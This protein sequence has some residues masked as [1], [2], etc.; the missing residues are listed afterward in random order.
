MA[1]ASGPSK[2]SAGAGRSSRPTA[3]KT[4][5]SG[6]QR[7]SARNHGRKRAHA[8]PSIVPAPITAPKKRRNPE[9]V[10]REKEGRAAAK[11]EREAQKAARKAEAD[12][13]RAAKQREKDDEREQ[14]KSLIAKSMEQKA[15]EKEKARLEKEKKKTAAAAAKEDARL[16]KEEARVCSFCRRA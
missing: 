6:G 8:S 10:A 16:E 9:E 5:G 4:P 14:R 13:E 15:A 3:D 7:K 2:N 12:E 11:A 1:T